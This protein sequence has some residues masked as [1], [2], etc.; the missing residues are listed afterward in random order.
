MQ[1]R[2]SM[3]KT[4]LRLRVEVFDSFQV[5]CNKDNLMIL[6]EVTLPEKQTTTK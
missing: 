6:E 2:M 1:N 4:Y 5:K 3:K